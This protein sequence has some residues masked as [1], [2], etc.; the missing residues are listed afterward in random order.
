MFRK[1]VGSRSAETS[2]TWKSLGN[3]MVFCL[4]EV[5]GHLNLHRPTTSKVT[6]NLLKKNT[7]YEGTSRWRRC[8]LA[9]CDPNSHPFWGIPQGLGCVN[10][11]GVVSMFDLHKFWRYK[12]DVFVPTSNLG[13]GIRPASWCTM[14]M[15]EFSEAFIPPVAPFLS[16]PAVWEVDWVIVN[17][18]KLQPMYRLTLP[19][20]MY[21]WIYTVIHTCPVFM[22]IYK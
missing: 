5:M 16:C 10:H 13:I 6:I 17:W 3:L 19:L 22:Y 9:E 11:F 8:C 21:T 20:S 1:Q 15:N 2:G 12:H 14:A 4:F 7:G 18:C